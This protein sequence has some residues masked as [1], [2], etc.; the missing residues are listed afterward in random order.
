MAGDAGQSCGHF[1]RSGADGMEQGGDIQHPAS[2]IQRSMNHRRHSSL[3]APIRC[4]MLSVGCWVFTSHLSS[5]IAAPHPELGA[6]YSAPAD[7]GRELIGTLAP[8]WT[9]SEWIG[10]EPRTLASMRGKVVLV[11]WWAA[12]DCPYCAASAEGL[13]ELSSKYR[14]RGL[15]V[16]GFYHHKARSPLTRSHV[17]AQVQRL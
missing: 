17:E 15:T 13:N 14:D 3:A 2:K 7:V 6:R 9:V 4:W 11:R 16:I 1:A 12:P 8:E 5:V 10:S